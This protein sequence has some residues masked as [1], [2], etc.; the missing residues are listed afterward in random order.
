[1]SQRLDHLG[2]QAQRSSRLTAHG[3]LSA[4]GADHHILTRC[5]RAGSAAWRSPRFRLDD[6]R[7]PPG[8]SRR[9]GRLLRLHRRPGQGSPIGT[10][11]RP[12]R[13]R[14]AAGLPGADD[15]P[16]SRQ[17]PTPVLPA[18]IGGDADRLTGGRHRGRAPAERL[19]RRGRRADGGL[20]RA[21]PAPVETA[22]GGRCRLVRRAAPGGAP[23]LGLRL[24]RRAWLPGVHGHAGSRGAG[25]AARADEM[26][27]DRPRGRRGGGRADPRARAH[28]GRRGG[29]GGRRGGLAAQRAAGPAAAAR[30]G[31]R[32]RRG[33]GGRRSGTSPRG[34]CWRGGCCWRS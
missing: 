15:R 19:L 2:R 28:A 24:Q 18:R 31:R 29:A 4:S 16:G 5:D 17:P 20:A 1:M 3:S 27:H 13:G 8:V 22:G 33:L 10:R 30:R 14:C 32:R 25:A 11:D 7:P 9:L 12:G 26:A 34:F 23:L 6:T 21:D